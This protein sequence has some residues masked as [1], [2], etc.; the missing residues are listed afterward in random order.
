MSSSWWIPVLLSS[1]PG[2]KRS[3]REKKGNGEGLRGGESL[4]SSPNEAPIYHFHYDNDREERRG[5]TQQEYERTKN[6][7]VLRIIG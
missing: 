7:K 6:E 1:K 2:E 3:R 4:R 5:A